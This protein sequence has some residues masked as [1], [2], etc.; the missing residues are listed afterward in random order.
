[1][2]ANRRNLVH[3]NGQND[4]ENN[5][6][7]PTVGCSGQFCQTRRPQRKVDMRFCLINLVDP[8]KKERDL[9]PLATFVVNPCAGGGSLR[10]VSPAPKCNVGPKRGSC[11]ISLVQSEIHVPAG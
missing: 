1:M 4:I 11:P 6:P 9:P 5:Y 2:R 7:D 10:I 8:A 3:W